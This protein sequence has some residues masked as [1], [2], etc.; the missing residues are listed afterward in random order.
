MV[1]RLFE[2]DFA[3]MTAKITGVILKKAE[4]ENNFEGVYSMVFERMY[5][6]EEAEGDEFLAVLGEIG[7]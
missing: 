4:L 1:L 6:L 2:E 5:Q 7:G 3:E